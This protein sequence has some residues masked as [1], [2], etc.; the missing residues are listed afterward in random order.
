MELSEYL[1]KS[2]STVFKPKPYLAGLLTL[3]I[4]GLIFLIGILAFFLEMLAN[5]PSILTLYIMQQIT[6]KEMVL[7][8]FAL[9]G[10]GYFIFCIIIG[11]LTIIGYAFILR[12]IDSEINKK[13][14]PF[15]KGLGEAFING[16]KLLVT[17]FVWSLV[18]VI[19]GAIIFAL[20]LIPT[21]GIILAIIIGIILFLYIATGTLTLYGFTYKEGI[22]SGI[23]HAFI[24][25]L[26][27]IHLIG[28][29]VVLVLIIIAILLVLTLLGLIPIL[30][31]IIYILGVPIV[32]VLVL[33]YSYC[34]TTE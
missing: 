2:F 20:A 22:G 26:K 30:G 8:I 15:F 10:V 1:S 11:I 34:L 23:A 28:Y 9:L 19:A 25:P 16:L 6:L 7:K 4:P 14:E 31:Q 33:T 17:T 18:T 32:W 13:S 12:K 3:I 27:K 29:T 24:L 21:V 5:T